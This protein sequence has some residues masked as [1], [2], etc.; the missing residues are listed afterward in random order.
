MTNTEQ[1]L[2]QRVIETP[3]LANRDPTTGARPAKPW[4]RAC[5]PECTLAALPSPALSRAFR[6]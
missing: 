3:P 6:F 2:M 4:V 5:Y 1:N